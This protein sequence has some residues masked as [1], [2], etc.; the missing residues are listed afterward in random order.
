[1]KDKFPLQ[2][3]RKTLLKERWVIIAGLF[4]VGHNDEHSLKKVII[5]GCLDG[6]WF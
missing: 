2:N 6:Q 3:L 1:L 5:E 4:C